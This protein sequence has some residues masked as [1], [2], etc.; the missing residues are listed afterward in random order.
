MAILHSLSSLWYIYQPIHCQTLWFEPARKSLS[1]ATP[2]TVDKEN[3]FKKI[4]R[5]VTLDN[6]DGLTVLSMVVPIYKD[7]CSWSNQA[8]L[9]GNNDDTIHSFIF[10]FQNELQYHFDSSEGTYVLIVIGQIKEYYKED[11]SS[12]K[13]EEE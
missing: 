12:E 11:I 1:F 6:V 5:V 9:Y 10:L 13:Y 2:P 7:M 3:A 4:S 8:Y